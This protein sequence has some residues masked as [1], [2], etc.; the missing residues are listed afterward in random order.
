M[1]VAA[2]NGQMGVHFCACILE[3]DLTFLFASSEPEFASAT[4]VKQTRATISALFTFIAVVVF[5]VYLHSSVHLL[6]ISFFVAKG[7][8]PYILQ[9]TSMDQPKKVRFKSFEVH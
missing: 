9:P 5:V 7:N 3:R 4:V 8:I 2:S 1:E 6:D